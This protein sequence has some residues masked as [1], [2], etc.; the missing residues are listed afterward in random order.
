M[1]LLNVKLLPQT[2]LCQL[3]QLD[4]LELA[5]LVRSGLAGPG[6]VP[7]DLGPDAVLAGGG[8]G[9]HVLYSLLPGPVQGVQPSVHHQPA[10]PEYLLT[11]VPKPC[12]LF[13]VYKTEMICSI[14]LSPPHTGSDR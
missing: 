1:E 13:I 4:D 5:D 14:L 9:Q 11:Q 12:R 2:R 8:V 6:D 7:G 10:G 3:S